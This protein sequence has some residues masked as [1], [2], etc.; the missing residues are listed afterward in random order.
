MKANYILISFMLYFTLISC[1]SEEKEEFKE[2]N[3]STI[4]NDSKDALDTL[5]IALDWSPNVLH[6]GI[7]YA[8]KS[9]LL[10]ENGIYIEWFT[11]EVD[12]YQKKPIQRLIDREVD[13]AVGPSEHLFFYG[14]TTDQNYAVAIATLLQKDQSAFVVKKKSGIESPK[15]LNGKVY[16]GYKT[17]LEQ[18]IL[19]AMIKNDGGGGTFLSITPP[20]LDVWDAF[21]NEKGHAAWIFSH[22]EGALAAN[23]GVELNYFY[24]NE[25]GVPYGYSSV[26]M[27]NKKRQLN[28]KQVIER[29]L[30]VLNIAHK[31]LVN[32]EA[33]EVVEM[34]QEYSGHE[35]FKN[36]EFVTQAWLNIE[37]AF[38][39]ESGQWGE[40]SDD[41]WTDYYNWIFQNE[42]LEFNRDIKDVRV[43]YEHLSILK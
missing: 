22:W 14:D 2:I 36:K 12:N 3:D 28:Q 24:P 1:S 21:L 4:L 34:L 7:F 27:A 18:E 33:K 42:A 39:N 19:S 10:K 35:N 8:D 6:A 41:K 17:P 30:K 25:F 16:V 5:R 13:L 23:D 26:I 20:R 37:D 38:L 15:E 32:K 31:E 9:G 11:T 43:F 40:M 29:F